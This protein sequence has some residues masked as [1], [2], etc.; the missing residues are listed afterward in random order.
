MIVLFLYI[1]IG[2]NHHRRKR[3]GQRELAAAYR[4]FSETLQRYRLV[5]PL[6]VVAHQ[7]P[8]ILHAVIPFDSR[9]PRIGAQAVTSKYHHRHAVAPGV[10]N[11]HGCVL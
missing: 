8:R 4:G 7:I 5:I 1:H 6:D 3:R 9:P 2:S 10:V 11:T